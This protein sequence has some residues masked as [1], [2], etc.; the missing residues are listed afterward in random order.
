M[1]KITT[2][3]IISLSLPRN[4]SVPPG[5]I[6]SPGNVMNCPETKKKIVDPP[7]SG[8]GGSQGNWGAGGS[9]FQKSGKFHEL[10]RKS[11]HCCLPH[12][13]PHPYPTGGGGVRS[14][15]WRDGW[16]GGTDGREGGM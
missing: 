10:P 14:P 1:K 5:E 2:F 16:E 4:I 11:I 12:P 15:N 6:K 8:G 13:P 7:H 3:T 9:K